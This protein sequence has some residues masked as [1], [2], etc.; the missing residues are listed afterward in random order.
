M[1]VDKKNL[2]IIIMTHDSAHVIERTLRAAFRVSDDV[3]VI[4]SFSEDN[5]VEV[6][7]LAGC[8]VVSRAFNG[9]ADQRNWSVDNLP[10]RY[11]WQMH[12]DADEELEDELIGLINAVP[13]ENAPCDGY[14]IGRKVVFMGRVLRHGSVAKTWHCRIF[15]N[16]FGR[17]EDRLYDNHFVCRGS[18][19]VLKG[20][21]LDH[22]D[23]TI[24]EWTARH[25][26]WSDVEVREIVSNVPSK[27][28]QYTVAA[29]VGGNPIERKRFFKAKYYSLPLF[30]RVFAYFFYRYVI[31]LGFLDGV[32]GMIYH[33]LQGFWFRFL[34][35]AKI[36]E[37]RRRMRVS[38]S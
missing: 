32:E 24:S 27:D 6:C 23:N 21:V 35:D 26:Y 36:Y 1:S 3:H 11:S 16:G 30:F 29:N 8:H 2:S 38:K 15:R 9:Y 19:K 13:F 34:V 37:A 31:R 17:C 7:R 12:L 22:Q 33:I 14:I 10:L 4:D 25:N 28:R 5:T 20:Y 18:V